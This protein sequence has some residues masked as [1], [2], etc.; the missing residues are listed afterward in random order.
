MG[1][2]FSPTAVYD[3]S[4]GGVDASKNCPAD[5]H[6]RKQLSEEDDE[7][8]RSLSLQR[9]RDT[10]APGQDGEADFF[11]TVHGPFSLDKNKENGGC[12]FARAR[13]GAIFLSKNF[14]GV[15]VLA[16]QAAMLWS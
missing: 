15:I 2:R 10:T 8:I 14:W 1:L 12:V 4:S 11:W 6:R 7:P 16:A 9:I 3:G 13:E 5:K